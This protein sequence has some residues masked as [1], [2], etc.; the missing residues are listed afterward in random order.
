MRIGVILAGGQS[1]RMGADKAT[2]KLNGIR[3]V[4]HVYG[5]LR[6]QVDLVVISGGS[7]YDLGIENIADEPGGISGPA[8]GVLATSNWLGRVHPDVT[9]FFTAPVDGPFIPNDL[10]ERLSS[11]GSSSV[12]EVDNYLHPT[13]AYWM[14]E[15]LTKI[16]DTFLSETP[17]S[18]KR[19]AELVEAK[20][21]EW[22]DANAFKNINTLD[23]LG[24]IND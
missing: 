4:D 13:F 12:A 10:V 8:A 22:D 23:D 6:N 9:G 18:L 5:R 17:H 2:L 15:R 11:S 20:P 21:V 14:C 1:R 19:L 24:N 7:D 16:R 3:L